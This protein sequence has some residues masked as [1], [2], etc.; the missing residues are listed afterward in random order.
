MALKLPPFR[1]VLQVTAP[2]IAIFTLMIGLRI[3][4][5]ESVRAAVVFGAP[6]GAP[7][8]DGKTRLAWQLLTVLDDRGVKETVPM[9]NLTV[10]ATSKGK[11]SEWTGAS[12]MDGIAEA[13]FVFEDF[14]EGDDVALEVTLPDDKEPLA[15]GRAQW[16]PRPPGD[17]KPDV[18]N[19]NEGRWVRP[20]AQRGDIRMQVIVEGERLV[21]GSEASV[22][23]HTTTST[24]PNARLRIRTPPEPGMIVSGLED[25][26][27]KPCPGGWAEATMIAQGHVIGAKVTA[28]PDKDPDPSHVSEW[29]GAMPVA[30]GA[31]HIDIGRVVPANEPSTAVL[32]APNPRNVA[33]AE[34]QDRHGR[35]AAAALEPKVEPGDPLPHARFQLPPLAPGLYWIVASGEPRGGEHMT[36]ATIARA[37]LVGSGPPGAKVDPRDSCSTGPYLARQYTSGIQ[38]WVALDGLPE[39]SSKNRFRH[40]LGMAIAMIS[41]LAAAILEVLLLVAASREARITLQ[42]AELED[43]D[44]PTEA[45][46]AKPPGG[47]L[48]VALLVAVL[49]FALLAVLLIAKA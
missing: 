11:V 13:S 5:G 15:K 40:V 33:Y 42:L 24:F 23:I 34:L 27:A 8:P 36:G 39:R 25:N 28:A 10:R 48:V 17:P 18:D 14:K 41:L 30:A 47:G 20:T 9:K 29:F 4:A 12:N 32:V 35:I 3:G 16:S 26:E 22:W 44:R 43:E 6:P 21:P 31:F 7:G 49:G 46:T 19:G 37:F 1:R 45:V 38:R 2:I